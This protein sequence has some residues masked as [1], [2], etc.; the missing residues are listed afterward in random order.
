LYAGERALGWV[1]FHR[2]WEHF[3]QWIGWVAISEDV[4][5]ESG[6][7]SPDASFWSSVQHWIKGVVSVDTDESRQQVTRMIADGSSKTGSTLA[8]IWETIHLWYERTRPPITED[9]VEADQG[10]K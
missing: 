7:S 9:P 10:S 2:P 8:S 1:L 4:Y 6:I 5:P 3:R